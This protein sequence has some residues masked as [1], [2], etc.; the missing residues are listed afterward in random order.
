[1]F[2]DSLLH[3]SIL[4][5]TTLDIFN[6]NNFSDTVHRLSTVKSWRVYIYHLPMYSWNLMAHSHALE[7][8]WRGSRW[9]G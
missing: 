2:G 1:M 3:F 6:P 8:K 9:I 5:C 7:G 4:C